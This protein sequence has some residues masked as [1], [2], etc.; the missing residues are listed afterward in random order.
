ME[1]EG[2]IEK[3]IHFCDVFVLFVFV[4]YENENSR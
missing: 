1:N 2:K 4:Y 3:K